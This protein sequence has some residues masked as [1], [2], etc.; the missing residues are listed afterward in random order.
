MPHFTDSVDI[1]AD[2]GTVFAWFRDPANWLRLAPPELHLE[3]IAAPPLLELGS[4]LK[5]KGRRWGMVQRSTIEITG[6][7]PGKVLIEEQRAGPFRRWK[8]T[9]RFETCGPEPRA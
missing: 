4:R 7:E 3:I 5:L 8:H 1:Q 6:L 9:H 2:V